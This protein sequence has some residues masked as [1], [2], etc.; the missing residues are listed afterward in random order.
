MSRACWL[1]R[2]NGVGRHT[3]VIRRAPS[4]WS[5]HFPLEGQRRV[6]ERVPGYRSGPSFPRSDLASQRLRGGTSATKR[7]LSS[8]HD[9][10]PSQLRC[11]CQVA[12]PCWSVEKATGNAPTLNQHWRHWPVP[13]RRRRSGPGPR[14]SASLGFEASHVVRALRPLNYSGQPWPGPQDR[15]R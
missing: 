1:N 6:V 14:E 13:G 2:T 4:A 3:G 15:P 9:A 8:R 7:K 11:R 12:P 5:R 10:A